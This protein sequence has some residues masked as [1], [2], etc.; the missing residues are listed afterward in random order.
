MR[1]ALI[2]GLLSAGAAVAAPTSPPEWSAPTDP[3]R[4]ADSEADFRRTLARQEA[5]AK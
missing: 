1:S 2:A 5:S 3:F 4:V